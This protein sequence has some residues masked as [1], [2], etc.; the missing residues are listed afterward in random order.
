MRRPPLYD[1]VHTWLTNAT[2]AVGAE[3]ACFHLRSSDGNR[4][5]CQAITDSYAATYLAY[6]LDLTD[7][8]AVQQVLNT[9]E[10]LAIDDAHED[11]R[12]AQIAL[13]RFQLRSL[14][15]APVKVAGHS[16][17]VAIFSHRKLHHWTDAER[18]LARRLV[19]EFED[20]I[21]SLQLAH[22]AP[23]SG[24][25]LMLSAVPGVVSVL[26]ENL[27][28]IAT[29][30]SVALGP[31]NGFRGA[32]ISV[33]E[34]LRSSD[35]SHELRTALLNLVAGDQDNY[36]GLFRNSRGTWWVH[37]RR[38]TLGDE[39]QDSRA[40]VHIQPLPAATGSV[41]VGEERN[42]LESLGRI[43]GSVAHEIN[44]A[45]QHI[46]M[47]LQ[48]MGQA[49][50][51]PETQRAVAESA[52]TRA[53]RVTKKLLTF[54]RRGPGEFEPRELTELAHEESDL[55]R[56]S[57]GENHLVSLR[58]QGRALVRVDVRKIQ[59][60]LIN[61]CRNA[62]DASPLGSEVIIEAGAECGSGGD[63]GVIAVVDSGSGMP[64]EV[65]ENLGE[66]QISTKP[67]GMGTGFG[68]AIVHQ[69]AR[70]HGGE[71]VITPGPQGSG[72]RVA[73]HL[74]LFGIKPERTRTATA[75]APSILIVDDEVQLAEMLV[76]ALA[77]RSYR[78]HRCSSLATARSFL[79]DSSAWPDLVIV[80]V[81][82][83]DGNGLELIEH[84]R[85]QDSTVRC[86][87]ISGHVEVNAD[88]TL[89]TRNYP[90]LAKPF[91]VEQL[92]EAVETS[93]ASRA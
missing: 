85:Q 1:D 56:R 84:V 14:L 60:V 31:A 12:V 55:I 74:P 82:L 88:P 52:A 20:N 58:L 59:L 35:R 28:T 44:N 6:S 54:A 19:T 46:T 49:G 25:E 2:R 53:A 91:T 87:A 71:L 79:D 70:D 37:A 23:S 34:L 16:Q 75:D 48:E 7:C 72:T 10:P 83:G 50:S 17:A 76:R 86:L 22:A 42:R 90:F 80:D 45:L 27:L 68:L 26:D 38:S 43:A 51:D 61:L 77:A 47:S 36:Q 62:A 93:L 73:L 13:N 32:N 78:T 41:L 4:I 18:N 9:G 89:C 67:R 92:L 11:A 81:N 65:V 30:K 3:G 66:L 8:P 5:I 40:V 39:Q 64:S 33:D 57:V 29:S 15:Y 69:V 63:R 21:G 24:N